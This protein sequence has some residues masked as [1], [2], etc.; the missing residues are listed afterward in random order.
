MMDELLVVYSM[1]KVGSTTISKSLLESGKFCFDIHTL[2]RE[3]LLSRLQQNVDAGTI[4]STHISQ[5][6]F[7]YYKFR[8][9]SKVKIITLIRDPFSRNISAVFQN[10][11]QSNGTPSLA[12][13]QHLIERYDVPF[14]CNWIDREILKNTN[15]DLYDKPFSPQ[16]KYSVIKEGQFEIL[17][18]RTDLDDRIKAGII[19]DF[20][21]RPITIQKHN[22]AENK[23][24]S[25]LYQDFFDTGKL[26]K[27]WIESCLDCRINSKFFTK[28][29]RL[30]NTEKAYAFL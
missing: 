30:R 16:D 21:Q 25:E 3:L 4:P 26:S 12:Q 23:W 11:Q 7:L 29:E 28:E 27:E 9:T 24:Y 17:T 6:Q 14:A 1:G 15:I 5:S 18:I 8:S 22:A 10:L 19:S 20:V 13:I 2:D